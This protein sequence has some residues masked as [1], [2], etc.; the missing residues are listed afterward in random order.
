MKKVLVIVAH[1]DDAEIGMGMRIH[2]Y[3]ANGADVDVHCLSRG[4]ASPGGPSPRGD[5]CLRAGKVLGVRSYT[6]SDIPDSRFTGN[7]G[8]INAELFRVIRESRPDVVYTHYPDD[9]H[10][11][12]S[13]AGAEVT[14]VAQREVYELS[15]FRSPYSVRFE[16]NLFFLA[17]R[18]SLDA[19][20]EALT[21]FGSQK[22]LDMELFARLS[23]CA[24]RQHLH[25]RVVERFTP[26]AIAAEQFV[27]QRR[28]EFG[29]AE[30]GDARC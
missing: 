16:P 13:V 17:S 12:H 18:E 9:Q 15:Y 5:E 10:L 24:H 29:L 7:R 26:E 22:Q 1:P 8:A 25:H 30:E 21:C 3:S 28:I 27:I 19:K 2:W 6:F 4:S 11:D 23:R 20:Q 14:A